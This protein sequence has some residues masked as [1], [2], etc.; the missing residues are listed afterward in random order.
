[1]G[2]S[3][4]QTFEGQRPTPEHEKKGDQKATDASGKA[5]TLKV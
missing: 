5:H 1:L 4:N 2:K 3:L